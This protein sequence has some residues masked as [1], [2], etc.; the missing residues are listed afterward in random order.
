MGRFIKETAV[1]V[2]LVGIDDSTAQKLIDRLTTTSA[3]DPGT[4]EVMRFTSLVECRQAVISGKIHAVCVVP[5]TFE[6][7]GF[8]TFVGSIRVTNPLVPFCLV[9]TKRFL[10]ELPGYHEA[11]KERLSHYY[12]LALDVIDDDFSE[13]AG[14]LRDLFVADSVKCRALGQYETTPG[15]VIRLKSPRPYGFWLVIVASL[16][17][18]MIG[19]AVGPLLDWWLPAPKIPESGAH[20]VIGDELTH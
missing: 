18:A 7:D 19:G 9:G 17:A 20:T 14:L 5:E 3:H 12:K 11:W 16:L 15:A 8:T 4:F 2:G 13:N 6:P 1:K 10:N